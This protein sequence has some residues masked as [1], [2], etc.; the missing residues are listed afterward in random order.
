MAYTRKGART[1]PGTPDPFPQHRCNVAMYIGETCR[2]LLSAAECP[3]EKQH[4]VE[5]MIGN[6]LRPQIWNQFQARFGIKHIGEFYGSTEGNSN[7]CE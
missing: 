7:V 3:E 6:G 2:Y 1:L 4:R 5:M